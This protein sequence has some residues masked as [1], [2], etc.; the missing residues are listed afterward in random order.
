MADEFT[1]PPLT[2]DPEPAPLSPTV[3]YNPPMV[4]DSSPFDHVD[5]ENRDSILESIR[6]WA[7]H[8][9]RNWTTAWQSYLAYWLTAVEGWLNTFAV[10]ASAYIT[11]NAIPGFAWWY[12]TGTLNP[13]TGGSATVLITIPN[14][15]VHYLQV[16][17]LVI[18]TGSDSLFGI[19]TAVVD[20]THATVLTLG[21]LR[22]VPGPN[23][24]PTDDAIAAALGSDTSATTI[25]LASRLDDSAGPISASVRVQGARKNAS[26]LGSAFLKLRTG[27]AVSLGAHGDSTTYGQ[28]TQSPDIVAP[29]T[30]PLPDGTHHTQMR[31]PFPWPAVL[32][33]DLQ[34]IYNRSTITVANRGFSG[35][36][37]YASYHHWFPVGATNPGLDAVI[38]MLG[39]NDASASFVPPPYVGSTELYTQWLEEIMLQYISWGTG[40]ILAEPI[41]N[42]GTDTDVSIDT[43]RNALVTLAERY[44]APLI[45]TETFLANADRTYWSDDIHLNTNGYSYV[46][47][48]IAACLMGT[49]IQDPHKVSGNSKL[50]LRRT[51]DGPVRAGTSIVQNA[52]YLTPRDNSSSS[53]NGIGP[54]ADGTGHTYYSFFAETADLVMMPIVFISGSGGGSSMTFTLDGGLLQGQNYSD[55]IIDPTATAF[56]GVEPAAL[57]I[58]QS[59]AASIYQFDPTTPVAPGVMRIT[60][61]GWHLLDITH[62]R[63]S[64]SAVLEALEFFDWRVWK[65]IRGN[66]SPYYP[67]PAAFDES[68]DITAS[69]I[70]ALELYRRLKV[71][72]WGSSYSQAPVIRLRVT[73]YGVGYVDYEFRHDANWNSLADAAAL[74]V[75]AFNTEANN[76]I[77]FA[78]EVRVATML[79]GGGTPK[80]TASGRELASIQ[81]VNSTKSYQL[82][83]R[84]TNSADGT[85]AKTLKKNFNLSFAI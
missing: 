47:H 60:T 3:P 46:A 73:T 11:T 38:I 16:N 23:T 62:V 82:N 81:F 48:R 43:F 30:D 26:L 77:V 4:G 1:Y 18:E 22:G 75:G 31:S 15:S 25:E 28:D 37:A 67:I 74:A 57:T 66:F 7:R 69:T 33:S 85:T 54:S 20:A 35:D 34:A 59:S 36:Y 21:S 79:S 50:W 63:A 53:G 84:T 49:G 29:P 71:P 39:Q 2:P 17:D 55:K 27:V 32:Q 52:A 44:G 76:V 40:V 14:G 19:V 12:T 56:L 68:T 13:T 10:D 64:G 24:V 45:P 51:I 9:L 6:T 83:W 65:S 80:N 5:G 8:P 61:P 41:R 70:D 42:R 78:T 58:A 72:Q